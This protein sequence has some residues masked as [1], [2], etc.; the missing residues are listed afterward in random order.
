MGRK[1][2]Q[3]RKSK[4]VKTYRN[5]SVLVQDNLEQMR[6]EDGRVFE[7]LFLFGN[8]SVL[9]VGARRRARQVWR[10][11]GERIVSIEAFHLFIYFFL[12]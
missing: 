1:R 6:G 9:M 5:P 7:L 3:E 11:R 4:K 10:E 8:V 2:N 12:M